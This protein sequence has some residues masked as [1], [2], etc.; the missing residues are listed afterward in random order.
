MSHP[1]SSA[2]PKLV[3]CRPTHRFC[4]VH[5]PPCSLAVQMLL[6]LISTHPT[7]NRLQMIV[8]NFTLFSKFLITI[9]IL[10]YFIFLLFYLYQCITWASVPCRHFGLLCHT[11][12]EVS[13]RECGIA[14]R[15]H[16]AR[17]GTKFRHFKATILAAIRYPA[18]KNEF[19][20]YA[21]IVCS[22]AVIASG[23]PPVC[24]ARC[25]RAIARR[26]RRSR[27]WLHR[28][29]RSDTLSATCPT[30]FPFRR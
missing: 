13:G 22:L 27:A 16:A 19:W 2:A 3:R 18:E 20:K 15:Y 14:L 5:P 1:S 10:F 21:A 23:S 6:I 12:T 29:A 26:N 11:L 7:R 17:S 28:N 30:A 9:A 24:R 4:S 8:T 25:R